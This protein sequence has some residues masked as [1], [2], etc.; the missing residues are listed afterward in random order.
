VVRFD[1]T[2][3]ASTNPDYRGVKQLTPKVPKPQFGTKRKTLTAKPS[4]EL[5]LV[6]LLNIRLRLLL[7]L[8]LH[9]EL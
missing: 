3:T 1:E 8:E 6:Q 4:T 2:L 5:Y 9:F 7:L